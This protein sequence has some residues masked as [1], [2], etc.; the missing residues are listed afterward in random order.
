ML[1]V[2]RLRDILYMHINARVLSIIYSRIQPRTY[3]FC[4]VG[5]GLRNNVRAG[6]YTHKGLKHVKYYIMRFME[7]KFTVAPRFRCPFSV[8]LAVR[9]S[10]TDAAL[11]FIT[12]IP[13][14]RR[15]RNLD[16]GWDAGTE[17]ITQP[18]TTFFPL[19]FPPEENA[20]IAL[21]IILYFIVMVLLQNKAYT[22]VR[23]VIST[24]QNADCG[25]PDRLIRRQVILRNNT[26]SEKSS[27]NAFFYSFELRLK[28]TRTFKHESDTIHS[29]RTTTGC[30]SATKR[31]F[32]FLLLNRHI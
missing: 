5:E 28:K 7:I 11:F 26:A 30:A 31:F 16:N 24:K 3:I 22:Q 10:A 23:R 29:V 17:P 18:T 8:L 6:R 12:Y 9:F 13:R 2:T 25:D 4:G 14:C 20:T 21:F 19:F 32:F 27:E 1:S 15:F